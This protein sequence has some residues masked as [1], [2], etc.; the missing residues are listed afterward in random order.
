MTEQRVVVQRLPL[1]DNTSVLG[2]ALVSEVAVLNYDYEDTGAALK[3]L[4]DAT[5]AYPIY[6]RE[7]LH[8]V[9]TASTGSSPTVNIGDGTTADL[10]IDEAD[11]VDQTISSVVSSIESDTAGGGSAFGATLLSGKYYVTAAPIVVTLG[12]S[13]TAGAGTVLVHFDRIEV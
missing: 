9:R 8:I 3:L 4:I 11:I 10:W 7:V 1:K 2:H 6:I 5:A 13:W 12:G